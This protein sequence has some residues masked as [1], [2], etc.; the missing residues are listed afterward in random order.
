M[1]GTAHG[2]YCSENNHNICTGKVHELK[3]IE[4]WEGMGGR[5][6][7]FLQGRRTLYLFSDNLCQEN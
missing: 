5:E 6:S 7:A 1:N 3:F 4:I 2:K